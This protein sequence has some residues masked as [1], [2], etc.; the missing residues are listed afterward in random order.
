MYTLSNCAML[1][2]SACMTCLRGIDILLTLNI[3]A[4]RL[5]DQRLKLTTFGNRHLP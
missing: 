2:P 4:K 5:I 3:F 1:A